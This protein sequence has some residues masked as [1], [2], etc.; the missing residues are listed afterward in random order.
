MITLLFVFL[1]WSAR[2]P[3][4][5]DAAHGDGMGCALGLVQAAAGA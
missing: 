2:G 4:F 1:N 5:F 3:A